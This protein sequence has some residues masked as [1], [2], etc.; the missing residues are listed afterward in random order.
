MTLEL[1]S[2]VTEETTRTFTDGEPS[3]SALDIIRDRTTTTRMMLRQ[4]FYT[5][6]SQNLLH[7][8]EPHYFMVGQDSKIILPDHRRALTKR[9]LLPGVQPERTPAKA[10][11]RLNI[12]LTPKRPHFGLPGN[13]QGT[14][15]H[16]GN[17]VFLTCA[18]V[19][20]WPRPPATGDRWETPNPSDFD[21]N[22]TL[23]S[24]SGNLTNKL[25]KL[26]THTLS[27]KILAFPR[28]ISEQLPDGRKTLML[29]HTVFTPL[30]V[31]AALL[32]AT[33]SG[34][35]KKLITRPHLLPAFPPTT[36]SSPTFTMTAIAVNALDVSL[37][38][39]DPDQNAMAEIDAAV[40]RLLPNE[41]SFAC[42]TGAGCFS[43]VPGVRD[44]H[45]A[46][47]ETGWLLR[48]RIA[49]VRGS[50]GGALLD[51]NN[52]LVG[53]EV[54]SEIDEGRVTETCCNYGITWRGRFGE[55]AVDHIIPNLNTKGS[56]EAKAAWEEL[57]E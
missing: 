25:N 44:H 10:V 5:P 27:A 1:A 49:G 51:E 57:L 34:W 11:Y 43:P 4:P 6:T 7:E 42:K 9:S 21:Y 13:V 20:Q 41:I 54:G 33:D 55:F 47:P 46:A 31:D 16:L 22:I 23:T 37:E 8:M 14:A 29:P 35:I 52:R 56:R 48:H 45:T 32:V 24:G 2:A 18:H 36:L 17:S 3:A 39:Y 50:S 53:M 28:P 12:A 19:L 38:G 15:I 30:D 26:L 40:A